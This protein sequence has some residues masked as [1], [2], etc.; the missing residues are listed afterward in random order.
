MDAHQATPQPVEL[1]HETAVRDALET[2][3]GSGQPPWDTGVTPPE[4][5][6]IVEGHGK[7][8][9]GRALEL[10]CGTGTNS[11]YLAQHGWEVTGIDLID[12]AIRQAEEKAASAGAA[13]RLLRGD[14]TRLD[15][16]DVSGM[17]DL[18]FDLSCFCGIPE[19]RRDAYAAGVTQR[20]SPG[21]RL[22]MFGYGPEAFDD[23][24]PF[25]GV[26]AEELRQRFTGW[27]LVDITPGTNPF[28]TFWFTLR[29]AN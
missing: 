1:A 22:L 11:V 21:A 2:Y 4:L 26:T 3:Y 20:T 17:Y 14:A 18:I 24:E 25:P 10:G 9:P 19:H 16:L 23:D 27:D 15:G 6:N 5:V 8:T 12:S 29:R 28:P 13:V 7:L